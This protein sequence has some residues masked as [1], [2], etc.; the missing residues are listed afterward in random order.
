MKSLLITAMTLVS[1]M[2]MSGSAYSADYDKG[3]EAAQNG[4]FFFALEEWRPLAEQGLAVI[5]PL[6]MFLKSRT[7]M[8]LALVF[9]SG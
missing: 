8:L 1:L 2:L 4:V 5:P 6:I 3:L 7:S 9:V